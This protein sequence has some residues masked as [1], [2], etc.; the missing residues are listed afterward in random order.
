M[1]RNHFEKLQPKL[2]KTEPDFKTS[3]SATLFIGCAVT[4]TAPQS[5]IL[6]D[7]FLR[8]DLIRSFFATHT[9]A[10]GALDLQHP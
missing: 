1:N 3:Q 4:T 2:P 8:D 5:T 9:I 7:L 6:A 10:Y